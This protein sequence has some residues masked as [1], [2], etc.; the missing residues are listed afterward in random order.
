M[1][2]KLKKKCKPCIAAKQVAGCLCGCNETERVSRALD[3]V[4]RASHW[5]TNP[6]EEQLKQCPEAFKAGE[7]LERALNSLKYGQD[8]VS[9]AERWLPPAGAIIP[10][11]V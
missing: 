3:L 11:L 6:I 10:P 1:T 4:L 7:L 2:N 9:Q 5:E 8:E